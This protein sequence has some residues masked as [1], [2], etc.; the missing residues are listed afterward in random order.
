MGKIGT[1]AGG[2]RVTATGLLPENIKAGET[3]TVQQ[4]SKVVAKV[5][6]TLTLKRIVLQSYVPSGDKTY[7]RGY[8]NVN[9]ELPSIYKSLTV[10]NFAMIPKKLG[11]GGGGNP[12]FWNF[13]GFAY[14]PATGRLT[15]PSIGRYG[16]DAIRGGVNEWDMICYYI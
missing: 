12:S 8:Y 15:V 9:E 6:G 3:V 4:G 2:G 11:F 1:G 14:D 10:N 16:P 7:Y 5:D 13:E